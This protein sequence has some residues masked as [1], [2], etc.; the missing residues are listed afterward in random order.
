[1]LVVHSHTPEETYIRHKNKCK[2]GGERKNEYLTKMLTGME[3][4]LEV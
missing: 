3:K 2:V 4:K 1:V